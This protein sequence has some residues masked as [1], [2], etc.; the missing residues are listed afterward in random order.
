MFVAQK[1]L[2]TDILFEAVGRM[3]K[4]IFI[5]SLFSVIP[6]IPEVVKGTIFQFVETLL[7]TE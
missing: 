1:F 5:Y 2:W 7:V 4:N 3:Q 6:N